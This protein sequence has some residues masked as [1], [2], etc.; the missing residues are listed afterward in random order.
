MPMANVAPTPPLS[1]AQ[2]DPIFS[3]PALEPPSQAFAS[4][5]PPPNVPADVASNAILSAFKMSL[6]E[7]ESY[8]VALEARIKCEE[9]YVRSLRSSL[10]RSREQDLKL[11]ARISSITSSA[12]SSSSTLGPPAAVTSQ[13]PGMR[14]AWK[15]LQDDAQRQIHT[16]T[17]FI[18]AVKAHTIAPLRAFHDAQDRIRRRIKED[19]RNSLLDYEEMRMRELKRIKRNYDRACENLDQLKA[20]QVAIDE[21]R[22]LLLSPPSAQQQL[23]HAHYVDASRDT[24]DSHGKKESTRIGEEGAAYVPPSSASRIQLSQR[25]FSGS[26]LRSYSRPTSSGSHNE[27]HAG[28]AHRASSDQHPE[29][30]YSPQSSNDSHGA[31][32]ATAAAKKNAGAFFEALRHRDTWDTARKDVAKKTNALITK[33]KEGPGSPPASNSGSSAGVGWEREQGAVVASSSAGGTSGGLFSGVTAVGANVGDLGA[34]LLARS[35]SVTGKN[36]QYVQNLAVRISKAKRE[37]QEADKLYRRAIFDVETLAL[38]RGKTLAAARTSVLACRREL[39]LVC[40]HAWLSLSRNWQN[41]ATTESSLAMHFGESLLE[42]GASDRLNDELL[43][44]DSRL[45]ILNN[46]SEDGPVPYVNFWHGECRSLLFGVS[47]VDYDFA[48][49]QRGA[50]QLALS[51]TGAPALVQPPLIVTKCVS[52]IEEYGL[53]TPG[54]YRLS[55]KHT[56]IQQL[57]ASFEKDE[58]RFQFRVGEDE[59]VAVAGVLK[60]WLRELPSAVMPMPR[61]EKIKITHSLEEQFQNGFATLKGRIRRLPLINQVT[62]K[63]IVEHLAVIAANSAVN[64]MTAKNLSVVFGPVLLTEATAAEGAAGDAAEG[65]TTSLAAAMEEDS[66]CEILITYCQEIFDLEKAGAPIIPPLPTEIS[67][68]TGKKGAESAWADEVRSIGEEIGEGEPIEM[69]GS[70]EPGSTTRPI[71]EVSLAMAAA[72]GGGTAGEEGEEL[73]SPASDRPLVPPGTSASAASGLRRTNAVVVPSSLESSTSGESGGSY[74]SAPAPIP[75]SGRRPS[76]L[77]LEIDTTPLGRVPYSN[78][79]PVS[80]G[81]GTGVA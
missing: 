25:R 55:A 30:S 19:I 58:E 74:D 3:P 27:L 64:L 54:I 22:S 47:L 65:V 59:A 80:A 21:Q 76:G 1:S 10:E 11:D 81:A 4:R 44:L 68:P 69:T 16:R 6:E 77:Q 32:G 57:C 40:H 35:G 72:V 33:M 17:H 38:R 60:Q 20:Q 39:S 52:Y 61:E 53:S 26:K 70:E 75:A 62:L 5:P 71:G 7:V 12:S 51:T 56:A 29:S 9:E 66:V 49:T 18:E 48:R 31:G 36:T 14:R 15:G 37:S 43:T 45:P 8:L 67:S 2:P 50:P 79:T 78:G 23:S 41:L 42:L 73:V 46:E 13:L 24:T 28:Q 34:N 63:T